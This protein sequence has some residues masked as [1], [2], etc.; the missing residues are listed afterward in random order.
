MAKKKK[1]FDSLLDE[2]VPEKE[3][4][5]LDTNVQKGKSIKTQEVESTIEEKDK[6]ANVQ[7][8][9]RLNVIIDNSI[10]VELNKRR[11]DTGQKLWEIAEEYL[12]FA[13]KN[14]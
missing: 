14:K 10:I 4:K 6:S 13:V 11:A 8:R 5:N 1:K 2:L 12:R 3:Q 7:K 9:K